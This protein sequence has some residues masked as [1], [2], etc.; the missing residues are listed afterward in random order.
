MPS[1]PPHPVA[2]EL[3]PYGET[4][5]PDVR[6][7]VVAQGVAIVQPL[8]AI[9][10]NEELAETGSLGDGWLPI[11]AADLLIDLKAEQ[12]IPAML[13]EL[14]GSDLDAI[15]YN[16]VAVR[17]P[18]LGAAVFEPAAALMD[19][20]TDYDARSSVCGVLAELNVSDERVFGWCKEVFDRDPVLGAIYFAE[21]GDERALPLLAR[22]IEEFEPDWE[23]Q[24]PLGDLREFVEAYEDIAD[25]LPEDL[26][27]IVQDHHERAEA[28]KQLAASTKP[29]AAKVG[30]NDPC[31][32]GKG[33]KF[34]KCCGAN[35]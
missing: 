17:L 32:C 25:A 12:A 26:A 34:K 23:S 7:R 2:L 20:L 19:T 18:E 29:V 1:P 14:V 9:L 28:L 24:P 21:C 4:L 27:D 10:E 15:L 30:R 22:A 35:A 6:A 5:P 13:R 8:I 33:K 16:K 31:P 11:H 3:A